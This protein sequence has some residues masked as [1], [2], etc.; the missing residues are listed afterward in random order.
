MSMFIVG[1]VLAAAFTVFV[2][3]NRTP[4]TLTF[5]AWRYET[6]VGV[7]VVAAL[8]AGALVMYLVALVREQRLR[9]Q[10][11]MAESRTRTAE[12]RLRELEREREAAGEQ[13]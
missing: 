13:A 9:S 2:L 11:R 6:T 5:L 4:V 10:L 12:A 7:A 3:Q 1:I 8:V